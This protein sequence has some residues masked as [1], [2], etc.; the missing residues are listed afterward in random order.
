MRKSLSSL[1]LLLVLL[2]AFSL[3]AAQSEKATVERRA[4][5]TI[6]WT[7]DLQRTAAE[8][9]DEKIPAYNFD[10]AEGVSYDLDLTKPHGARPEFA[11]SRPTARPGAETQTRDEQLPRGRRRLQHAPGRAR[12]LSF[13]H[14][15]TRIDHR[16]GGA[17]QAHPCRAAEQLASV[18]QLRDACIA[19]HNL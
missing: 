17:K 16:L 11:L 4:W 9:V 13:E 15:D 12:S 14:G 2:G 7:T 5:I 1:S 3:T 18:D 19:S 8:L 10:I 6:L